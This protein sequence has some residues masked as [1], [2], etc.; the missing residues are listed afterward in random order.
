MPNTRIV[1]LGVLLVFIVGCADGFTI[2]DLAAP[3]S[4]AHAI[5]DGTFG[6]TSGFHFMPPLVKNPVYAG[7]FDPDHEP[8]VEV[9]C[10]TAGCGPAVHATFDQ[11]GSD[12]SSSV[13]ASASDE[14]Y[15]VNWHS[16]QTGALAGQTYRIRVLVNDALLGFVDV[17]VVRTGRD[18]V[19]ARSDGLVAIIAGQ[20][21][22]VKFRIETDLVVDLVVTPAEATVEVGESEQFTA[23]FL[24]LHGEEVPGP[25]VTWSSS[26]AGVAT[27]WPD[28][29]ATGVGAG[30]AAIVA[31]AGSLTGHAVLTVEAAEAGGTFLTPGDTEAVATLDGWSV[32]CLAWSGRLCTRPQA[33]MD[34]GTC[35][36]Y[37]E[38][39]EWHDIT[40][41]NNNLQHR[42]TQNF[43][44][45]AAGSPGHDSS[46]IGG[47]PVGPR[48]CGL[49]SSSHPLCALDQATFHAAGF[50]I[51][52][53]YGLMLNDVAC[54]WDNEPRLTV[55]CTAW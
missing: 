27:V 9:L 17:A 46:G 47:A 3:D 7:T 15:M 1:R 19:N 51:D 24:N 10:M 35:G 49:Q 5:S 34:C 42:T 45:I 30:P 8:V 26:D 16:G 20:T 40:I 21:L 36:A 38:C 25:A 43:C 23:M 31:S 32:R 14:H 39:G 55:E 33:M 22:P 29:V 52:D 50:G 11:D 48:A 54:G 53:R 13:R 18:A 37:G 28:G 41:A 6:G 44:A 12:G 2:T 4:P